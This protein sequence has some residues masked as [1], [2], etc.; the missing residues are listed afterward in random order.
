MK[1]GQPMSETPLTARTCARCN[2]DCHAKV[3]HLERQNAALREALRE[4]SDAT[5]AAA[6][7]L[8]ASAKG[9]GCEL[10]DWVRA[11]QKMHDARLKARAALARQG[12]RG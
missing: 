4:L 1:E 5:L 11:R 3:R 10:T 2:D 12:E 6:R 8:N 7:C 9:D